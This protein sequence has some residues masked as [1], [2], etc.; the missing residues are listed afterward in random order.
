VGFD[1]TGRFKDDFHQFILSDITSLV[2]GYV[3]A[4]ATTIQN[5][6]GKPPLRW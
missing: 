4:V 1:V 3:F 6:T 2:A 5:H